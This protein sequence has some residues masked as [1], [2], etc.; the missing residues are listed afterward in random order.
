MINWLKKYYL[1]GKFLIT[2]V[3]LSLL[4]FNNCTNEKDHKLIPEDVFSDILY[5]VHLG[6]GLLIAPEVRNIFSERD[7]SRNYLDIIER[8]GYSK[9]QME[10]TLNYYFLKKPKKLIKIYDRNIGK[11]S[12]MESMLLNAQQPLPEFTNLWQGKTE[13][14]FPDTTT[15]R[16]LHFKQILETS[17]SYF[18]KFSA[19]VYPDDPS[20]NPHFSALTF[21]ADSLGTGK[22][23]LISCSKYFKDGLP[24]TYSVTIKVSD[25]LPVVLSINF[26]DHNNSPEQG[27]PHAK[28]SDILLHAIP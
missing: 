18:L 7:T 26:F 3:F 9:E 24:H 23:N 15:N 13:F 20:F 1:S 5:E 12:E 6:N 14:Y 17:G 16:K 28:I 8:Y 2:A 19:T 22:Q 10:N 11:L 21:H 25:Q 4:S 27:Q